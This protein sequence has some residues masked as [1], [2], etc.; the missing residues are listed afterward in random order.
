MKVEPNFLEP[1]DFNR[2]K[3]TLFDC[4][5]PWYFHSSV[6]Y[7]PSNLDAIDNPWNFQ[8]VHSFYSNYAPNSP[9]IE[10]LS[11]IL[12]KIKP[13]A[14][15]KIKANLIT[16]T[17]KIIEHNMHIDVGPE[18][19]CNTAIFYINTNDGYTKFQSGETMNSEENKLVTFNSQIQHTGTSCTTEKCRIVLN[20]NYY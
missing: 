14:I 18:V 4:N 9:F 19:S 5:F 3:N 17:E 13:S 11:P 2:I 20:L 16:R 1:D 8:F 10:L 6:D 15:V 7:D 12:D